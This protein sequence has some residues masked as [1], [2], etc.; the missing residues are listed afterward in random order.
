MTAAH[1][2][3]RGMGL[4]NVRGFAGAGLVDGV[5]GKSVAV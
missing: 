5:G 2:E 4:G 1:D 3:F